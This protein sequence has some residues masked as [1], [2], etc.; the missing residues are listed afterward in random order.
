MNVK[1]FLEQIN[2]LVALRNTLDLKMFHV[3]HFYYITYIIQYGE[4]IKWGDLKDI[5]LL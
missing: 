3:E 4:V 1:S 5:A 2:R